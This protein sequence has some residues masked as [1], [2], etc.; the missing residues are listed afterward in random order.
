MKKLSF[1]G[2][3]ALI[4]DEAKGALKDALEQMPSKKVVLFDFTKENW[5]EDDYYLELP[6]TFLYGKYNYADLYYLHTA[7]LDNGELY[8]EGQDAEEG[9]KY[10]FV[11]RDISTA[12]LCEFADRVLEV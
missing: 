10:T 9:R 2:K 8:V 3:Q 7:Y 6:Q 5:I 1:Y 12:D 4:F 11:P